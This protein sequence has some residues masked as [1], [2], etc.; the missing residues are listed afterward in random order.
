MGQYLVGSGNCRGKG[1]ICNLHLQV[2]RWVYRGGN[3]FA[4][5]LFKS[6]ER[7][8][9][10]TDFLKVLCKY[11]HAV[12]WMILEKVHGELGLANRKAFW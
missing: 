12:L 4:K 8:L 10:G 11:V 2:N 5:C 3:F 6:S 1:C 9:L 7:I